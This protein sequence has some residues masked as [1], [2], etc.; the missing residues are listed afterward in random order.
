MSDSHRSPSPVSPPDQVNGRPKS[1]GEPEDD[2]TPKASSPDI[3]SSDPDRQVW[4]EEDFEST[5]DEAG[6]F[7]SMRLGETLEGGRFVIARKLG[8]VD[9]R[10]YG[11]AD[12]RKC[13]P[14]VD[15]PLMTTDRTEPREETATLLE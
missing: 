1:Q 7:Y 6:G 15:N 10:A 11:L 8:W 13:V 5:V 9:F 3:A 2:L 14:K 4:P 12:D